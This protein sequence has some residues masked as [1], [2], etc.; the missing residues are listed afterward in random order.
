MII[1]FYFY[2][3][4]HSLSLSLSLSLTHTHA[5]THTLKHS[6][7]HKHKHTQARAQNDSIQF[8]FIFELDSSDIFIYHRLAVVLLLWKRGITRKCAH[9]LHCPIKLAFFLTVCVFSVEPELRYPEL[10]KILS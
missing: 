5:H 7:I 2:T 9:I 4:A 6:R 1:T 8:L 10:R 3:F